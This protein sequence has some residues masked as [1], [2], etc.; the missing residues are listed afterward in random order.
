MDEIKD[1][2]VRRARDIAPI[3]PKGGGNLRRQIAGEAEGNDLN[4]TVIVTANASQKGFNYGYYIHEGHM[5]E[6]GKKLR[7]E[8]TVEEF[9][10]QSADEAKWKRWL[11]EDIAEALKKA[12]W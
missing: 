12:G 5:A 9:L 11:E 1:D 6:A 8:G 4:Q 2:W 7:T 3:A 10:D